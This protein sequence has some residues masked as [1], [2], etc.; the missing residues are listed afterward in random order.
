M[1]GQPGR[2][3]HIHRDQNAHGE[4]A[5]LALAEH[6]A[7]A[8]IDQPADD[9]KAQHGRHRVPRRTPGKHPRIDDENASVIEVQHAEQSKSRQPGGIAL[10]IKPV[11]MLRQVLRRDPVFLRVVETP[12]MHR[13]QFPIH[14]PGLQLRVGRFFKAV[15]EPDEIKRRTNPSNRHNDVQ[16]TQQQIGPVHGV[17]QDGGHQVAH[18]D[19]S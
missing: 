18:H 13:P 2:N 12:A 5:L 11:Q 9:E 17:G 1:A 15:V 3:E 4:V 6:A 14:S 7:D 8:V 19:V 10:P 16:P